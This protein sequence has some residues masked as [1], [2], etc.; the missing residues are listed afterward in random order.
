[1]SRMFSDG[2]S[3]VID[4]SAYNFPMDNSITITSLDPLTEWL[5]D[6][7]EHKKYWPIWHL[8]KSYGVRT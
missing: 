4:P 5:P 7:S 2:S 8:M 6:A 3:S 1:M